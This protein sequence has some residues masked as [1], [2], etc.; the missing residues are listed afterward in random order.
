MITSRVAESGR[1]AERWP[2]D[3]LLSATALTSN[4]P[5]FAFV[6]RLA[7]SPRTI[8]GKLLQVCS[9]PLGVRKLVFSVDSVQRR[10]E[11]VARIGSLV[12]EQHL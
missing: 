12:D 7:P 4:G 9:G 6:L 10:D 3:S 11:I 8:L 1:I 5:S 2:A